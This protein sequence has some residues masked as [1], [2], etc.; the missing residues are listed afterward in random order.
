MKLLAK[1]VTIVSIFAASPTWADVGPYRWGMSR[2]EVVTASGGGGRIAQTGE[3]RPYFGNPAGVISPYEAAGFQFSANFHFDAAS[4]LTSILLVPAEG[5]DCGGIER[6]LI[7][8]YGQGELSRSGRDWV[9]PDTN[10]AVAFIHLMGLCFV[11]YRALS[12][13]GL[14]GL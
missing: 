10:N 1:L 5:T 8:V 11:G 12:P 14:A 3:G 9:D 2:D 4:R 13:D 7:G 6:A